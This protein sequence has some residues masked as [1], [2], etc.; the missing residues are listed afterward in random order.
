[1]ML[2]KGKGWQLC[3]IFIVYLI[4]HSPAFALPIATAMMI[5]LAADTEDPRRFSKL[6]VYFVVMMVL[7]LQ[8]I[9]THILYAVCSAASCAASASS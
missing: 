4:K 1:M 7:V 3:G 9:P 6:L 2:L 8:N 5:D